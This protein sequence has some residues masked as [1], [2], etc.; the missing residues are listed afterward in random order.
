[1]LVTWERH[2]QVHRIVVPRLEVFSLT[3]EEPA[4]AACVCVCVWS[5]HVHSCMQAE[6]NSDLV[7]S[8][9]ALAWSLPASL[10]RSSQLPPHTRT[11]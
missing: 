2:K 8:C 1:M 5:V 7:L 4:V 11:H 10:V 6:Y 3:G 9:E